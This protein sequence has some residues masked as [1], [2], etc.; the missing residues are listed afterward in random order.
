[1]LE[2]ERTYLVKYLP[3]DLAD[4]PQKEIIDI[5]F[6]R[7]AA[8]P[9]L[10]LR[11]QGNRFELTK[12]KR[13]EIADASAQEETTIDLSAQEFEALA[14]MEGKRLRKT[15]YDYIQ[16][17]RTAQIDVFQDELAGL[18]LADFEFEGIA[19]KDLFEMPE[20]CLRD[21]TQ[22]EFVAGGMLGDRSYADLEAEL[23]RRGYRRL[24]L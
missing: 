18:V 20:F 1:M 11:Q 4:C 2:L 19:E 15:R 16:A 3:A 21:V 13:I 14:K 5:Y 23:T 8:H 7:Q 17:G 22:E 12:K 9:T 24:S 6:P 10:R